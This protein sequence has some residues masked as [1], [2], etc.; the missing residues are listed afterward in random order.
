VSGIPNPASDR[1]AILIQAVVS[2]MLMFAM[3]AFVLDYGVLWVSRHQ[4]QNAAD[5]GAIAGALARAYDDFDD[6]PLAGDAT[7]LNVSAVV[8]TNPVWGTA[9]PT[10]AVTTFP[11]PPDAPAPA[12][13]VR[14][15]VYR[16]NTNG[17]AAL[18]T[19]FARIWGVT[20]QGVKATATAHV[21]AANATNCLRPWAIPDKWTGS[22]TAGGP[23]TPPPSGT[24]V[25]NPPSSSG[26]GTGLQFPTSNA[27]LEDLGRSVAPLTFADLTL[28][29]NSIFPGSVVPLHLTGGYAAA[30]AACNGQSIKVGDQVPISTSP[31]VAASA[32]LAA[33]F[34][35]DS[36]ASWDNPNK[37]IDGSCAPACGSPSPRLVAMA[38][39][40]V[41]LFKYRRDVAH[42]W[43]ACQ[44]GIPCT[45]CPGG[46]PC[47][48][49][50]NIVGFFIGDAT[51][52]SG[53]VTSY[54]G[55]LPTNPAEVP[56][57]TAQSSFLK[58]ITLVR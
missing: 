6:P 45:P 4:A 54:P 1:G 9:G 33:L 23:F 5:A 14:V 16:N 13:C 7:F 22:Y 55:S 49:I 18:P 46:A 50:V 57:L 42:S 15:D 3:S 37:T 29:A 28:P 20:S 12:R 51:G 43:T 47:V 34:P 31:A 36:S 48:S 32:D 35:D 44:P 17:S 10:T 26:A 24:D 21:L 30:A 8:G 39:F 11:C 2:L 52:A 56:L 38:V 19:W 41:G 40:D 53:Y 25:Y 58:A 27:S